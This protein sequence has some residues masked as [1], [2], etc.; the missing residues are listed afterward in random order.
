ML[1]IIL[2]RE[3]TKYE[4]MIENSEK[5]LPMRENRLAE[6]FQ[7]FLFFILKINS[8]LLLECLYFEFKEAAERITN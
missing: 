1:I 3:A 8:C 4:K 6:V 5:T 7:I 2:K